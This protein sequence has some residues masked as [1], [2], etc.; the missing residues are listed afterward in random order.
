MILQS[1][2]HDGEHPGYYCP[3]KRPCHCDGSCRPNGRR[4]RRR[5][6]CP[7]CRFS[8]FDSH[9]L[10]TSDYVQQSVFEDAFT[11]AVASAHYAGYEVTPVAST[12]EPSQ[13]SWPSHA[14]FTRNRLPNRLRAR[15]VTV[16]DACR[17]VI[18]DQIWW[19]SHEV[20]VSNPNVHEHSRDPERRSAG[21]DILL[22]VW[23]VGG[24]G[25]PVDDQQFRHFAGGIGALGE[26]RPS[27]G[28]MQPASR[29]ARN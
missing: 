4:Q 16:C 26:S 2:F 17:A 3:S 28:Y 18:P 29:E 10:R 12:V 9:W 15:Q 25:Q 7:S 8:L 27:K 19:H 20:E 1:I 11:R 13:G 14:D 21:A 24:L 22:H 5:P 6:E 23:I